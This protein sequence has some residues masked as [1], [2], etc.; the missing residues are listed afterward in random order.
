MRKVTERSKQ[1]QGEAK[2]NACAPPVDVDAVRAILR[3]NDFNEQAI[4][5]F[6]ARATS[7]VWTPV[8]AAKPEAPRTT[9]AEMAALLEDMPDDFPCF[10]GAADDVE[11]LRSMRYKGEDAAERRLAGILAAAKLAI[12]DVAKKRAAADAARA[13]REASAARAGQVV[14][15]DARIA[16]E[17]EPLA[18]CV[19]VGLTVLESRGNGPLMGSPPD[20]DR[21]EA[22]AD[23]AH[24]G[25]T[26]GAIAA[27]LGDE[28]DTLLAI[29]IDLGFKEPNR[30]TNHSDAQ[31]RARVDERLVEW[32]K[33]LDDREKSSFEAAR[34]AAE[35]SVKKARPR[36]EKAIKDG[37][38][39]DPAVW[40]ALVANR[41]ETPA[42]CTCH[43]KDCTKSHRTP[44]K[45][46]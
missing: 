26:N 17:L 9:A 28:Q 44:P 41:P 36:V 22:I 5:E 34:R 45:L 43:L 25:M 46:V 42:A 7:N 3:A 38:I 32:I 18:R 30:F 31:H 2:A 37:R 35:N 23:R 19:S 6:L 20:L 10:V 21:F 8:R 24:L 39:P 1:G 33:G 40:S 4:D 13:E 15:V 14:C 16:L 12:A 11:E 29:A 27:D